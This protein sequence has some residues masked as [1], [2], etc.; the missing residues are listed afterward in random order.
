MISLFSLLSRKNFFLTEPGVGGQNSS[1]NEIDL[2]CQMKNMKEVLTS[3]EHMLIINSGG[4][5]KI[6]TR[7]RHCRLVD[8]TPVSNYFKP[9]G[10]RKA[11]L[12]EVVLTLDEWEA[13]RL[14]D[15]E[16]LYQEEAA[17]SMNVSRATF[18]RIIEEARKKVAQALILGQALKIEGGDFKMTTRKFTCSDCKHH[19]EVDFGTGRLEEC[20]ACKSTNFHRERGQD[21]NMKDQ[22]KGKKCRHQ[23]GRHPAPA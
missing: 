16:S 15:F 9:A 19:W 21:G 4:D 13:I 22:C 11:S 6:M 5:G 10:V 7:P 17:E 23:R 14:A 3:Y 20:P 12:E 18:G 2:L 1:N 8:S